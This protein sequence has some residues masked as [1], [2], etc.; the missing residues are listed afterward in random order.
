MALT[1]MSASRIVL[2]LNGG[3]RTESNLLVDPAQRQLY[4]FG[5]YA[6]I[7]LMRTLYFMVSANHET[8]TLDATDQAYVGVS[9]RF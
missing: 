3:V 1:L 7:A 9:Y 5:G 4:W 8:G 2:E 6:D